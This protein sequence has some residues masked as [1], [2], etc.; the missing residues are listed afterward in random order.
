MDGVYANIALPIPLAQVFTYRIPETMLET[1][2][3]GSVVIV[4][5]GKKILTGIV[6]SVSST[7]PHVEIK[8]IRDTANI[9]LSE[10]TLRLAQWISDYYLAPLGETLRLFLPAG[11]GNISK[12]TIEFVATCPSEIVEEQSHRSAQRKKIIALLKTE[13]TLTVQQLRKKS[14]VKNLYGMMSE[15]EKL[16]IVTIS[17]YQKKKI[18]FKKEWTFTLNST[19]TDLHFRSEKQKTLWNFIASLSGELRV[20]VILKQYNAPLSMLK[21]FAQK[22]LITLYQKEVERKTVP[23]IDKHI[24]KGLSIKLNA[25]QQGAVKILS[26]ALNANIHTTFLLHGITGSGKTQVYIEAIRYALSLGKTAIVL[27]PEISLTPQTVKR[28]QLHF[29]EKVIWMHSRMTDAER[30]DAWQRI[31]LKQYAIAI[32][33]RSALFAPMQ[34][35]GLIIVDEEHESSYKQFDASPRYNARDVAV[36]RGSLER[37]V[38]LLGSATPSIESFANTI[39]GKFQLLTL[40]DRADAAVLPPVEI[41]NMIEERKKNYALAKT[42]AKTHGKK[43]FEHFSKSIS[44]LLAEKIRDRLQKKEGIILLQN[45]RGFAPFLECRDCGYIEQC[46]RCSVTMTYHATKKHLRCHYCGKVKPAPTVC[47]GCGGFNISMQGFGTQR[48]EEELLALFP[49]AKILRMDLDSTTRKGSHEKLLKQFGEHN[50]DI[51]LGT[52]M[53]AKGLDFPHVT[54]VG[55]ISADTQMMLP[56]FRS[57][58]RTFQLLTQVAGR[59]GRSSL[60][61]EVIVQTSQPTHYSLQHIVHHDFEGFYKEELHYRSSALYPPYSRVIAI[62]FK[63]KNEANVEAI[64]VLFGKYLSTLIAPASLLGPSQA[65]IAKVK[66]DF[67]WHLVVKADRATD[68]NGSQAK[69]AVLSALENIKLTAAKKRIRIS[70]DVDPAGI[71]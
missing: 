48:V 8:A 21:S 55:V 53:V 67:R 52:Q 11:I 17:E 24:A 10:T 63:G 47:S 28:F 45:R 26:S 40:P 69:R 25:H 39:N 50:A 27:V 37:A 14:G 13:T 36:V 34:N 12:R 29:E 61:G 66:N 9:H 51:L 44:S 38:V 41:V 64:A 46:D 23:E 15:F 42:E 70:V 62:E 7:A 32:G 54:L 16:G 4:P 2:Q 19:N 59:A 68:V 43:A 22:G 30:A 31:Q 65:V 58:E 71:L 1:I 57:A 3:R 18:S 5:F 35:L 6:V 33:P 49:E 20:P 60:Q 56:D